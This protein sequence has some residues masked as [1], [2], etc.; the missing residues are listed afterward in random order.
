[1]ENL[2]RSLLSYAAATEAEPGG[3][4]QVSLDTIFNQVIANIQD[5]IETEAA[6]ISCDPLPTVN[7]YPTQILQLFQ[8]LVSNAIKY[9]KPSVTPHLHISA[10]EAEQF[11]VVSIQG[12]GI[13]LATCQK[14]V[15]HH[16]GRIWV[17]A[18]L[19]VGSTFY[20][21]LQK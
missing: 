9:R 5:L 15:E 20:F 17:E 12:V 2:I 10:E 14:V 16:G 1:M 13:G 8:N 11:W 7:A 4:K 18:A 19:D 3:K 6:E 21:T